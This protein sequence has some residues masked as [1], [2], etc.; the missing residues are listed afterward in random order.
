MSAYERALREL[1]ALS[2]RG[3]EP[4]LERV[5][6]ALARLELPGERLRV[7]H[8]AGTNG[9]GSVTAMVAAGLGA[10]RTG[11]FTS[12]H[13]HR[14]T[15][16]VTI[17][18]APVTDAEL[19]EA[20]DWVKARLA[21]GPRLTFFETMTAIAFELFRRHEVDVAVLETGLGGRLDATNVIE[22]P[23]GCAITRV[24]LDHVSWLGE[25]L[26]SIA[27]EKAGILKPGRWAVIGEMPEEAAAVIAARASEIGAPLERALAEPGEAPAHVRENRAIASAVLRRLRAEGFVVDEARALATRWPG[28]LEE[29]DDV[30]LDAAHNEDGCRALAR[31]L[32]AEGEARTLIFGAMKD[33][34]WPAMLDALTPFVSDIVYAQAGLSRAEDPARFAEHRRG[35]IAT[36][37]VDALELARAKGRPIVVAG[38]IFLMAELRAALL[39]LE[40][41]PPIA[42]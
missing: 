35:L 17:E 25:D 4:G 5:H 18:G 8:V 16:R 30:L 13:L 24:G 19:V 42:L 12:P 2:A 3:I 14:L 32:E 9:K 40:V 34:A 1:Y 22:A 41:D 7:V 10:H 36:S 38:S 11:R 26:A 29:I 23:V 6:A 20:W 31:V 37:P 15:E 39:G 28:R 27:R 21:G 33:K